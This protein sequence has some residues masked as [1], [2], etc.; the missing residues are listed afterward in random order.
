M[1]KNKVL[2]LIR[3]IE[4]CCLKCFECSSRKVLCKNQ[5]IYHV[6]EAGETYMSKTA[7]GLKLG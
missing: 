2:V 5:S 3:V 4:A 7:P 6:T 1:C